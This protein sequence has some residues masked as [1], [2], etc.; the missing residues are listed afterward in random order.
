MD[1]QELTLGKY[2]NSMNFM[3]G[4]SGP[5]FS[6]ETFDILVNPYI[7]YH[8]FERR[9]GRTFYPKYEYEI[10]DEEMKSR[11]LKES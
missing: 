7:E 2:D 3:F 10:C 8:G 1:E 5:A 6:D 4:L 11:I 9:N